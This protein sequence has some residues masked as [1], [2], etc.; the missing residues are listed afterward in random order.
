MAAH[1]AAIL[2]AA[3]RGERLGGETPKAFRLLA[4]RELVVH[5]AQRLA[6]AERVKMVV[7]VVPS[8]LVGTARAML[9]RAVR[10]ADP[11]CGAVVVPGG[12]TRTQSVAAGLAAVP[13]DADVVLVHD[14]ARALAPVHLI[15]AV[16][17]AVRGGSPVVVP[18]VPVVDTITMV[19]TDP[20]GA[21]YVVSTPDRSL[22]RAVQ[23]PQGF[24]R[25]VLV[26]AHDEGPGE[27]T[28]DASM[29]AAL[30]FPVRAIP[31]DSAAMKITQPRDLSLAELLLRPDALEGGD[32]S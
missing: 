10:G 8:S 21:E 27:A 17:E 6:A 31:G 20:D 12:A 22:L 19:S 3:G 5:A 9:E 1:T 25:S 13:T 11:E 23:T 15:E 18:G 14:A 7:A 29:A 16:D 2:V 28:D 24:R 30:G 26:R 4:G 32:H